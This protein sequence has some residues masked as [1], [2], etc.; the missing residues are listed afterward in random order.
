VED[1]CINKRATP[2]LLLSSVG[3]KQR[4]RDEDTGTLDV[5]TQFSVE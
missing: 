3:G 1:I 5:Y 4:I 2:E